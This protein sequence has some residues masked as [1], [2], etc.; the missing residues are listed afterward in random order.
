MDE[1]LKLQRRMAEL[2]QA[3]RGLLDAAKAED[4]PL[5]D[6]ER[7]KFDAN[8]AEVETCK[9]RIGD[10]QEQ[11]RAEAELA[12]STRQAQDEAPPAAA[13]QAQPVAPAERRAQQ[14]QAQPRVEVRN[15]EDHNL[16]MRFGLW[17]LEVR[18]A[19]LG[20]GIGKR[21]EASMQEHRAATGM[22]TAVGSDG[23]FLLM[24]DVSRE[25][26][27][28]MYEL[29]AIISRVRKLPALPEG[30]DGVS[31]PAVNETS[32]VT[33]S[34][35][36]GVQGYWLA[37]GSAPT[38]SKPKLKEIDLRLNGVGALGYAT[39]RLLKFAAILGSIMLDAM[40]EEL[41][42]LTE[43]AII[44]GTGAGQ[45]K[46]ILNADALVTVSAEGGQAAATILAQNIVKIWSRV[47]ARCRPNTV[48]LIN[49]DI[50]PQLHLMTLA[51]GTG[52]V[53][54]YLPANGLAGE[55]YGT[56]FGRPVIPVEYCSTLGTI[57]DIMAVD[58]SQ[59][60]LIDGGA[61]ETASSIHV[62]FTQFE[63][64][65]RAIYYVDGRPAW[66]SPLTP[67]Q[68]SNTLSAFVALATRS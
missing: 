38:A 67:A 7:T 26:F 61:T 10:L 1:I 39:D 58:L 9:R 56:L 27:R 19:A 59:Y 68:G 29:G 24:T 25:I 42:F 37:E 50:E 8:K 41:L 6:E 57:G 46:G 23:G 5:N 11:E 17:L 51:V 35:M 28:R 2:V 66:H 21:L 4:R 49:Q 36:G 33:G 43:N 63:Q 55:P 65:F 62:L 16:A 31:I 32:R 34:R 45:P 18:A 48:F 15:H 14:R 47:W 20:Q 13:A 12:Q 53:P 52:G 22:G 40:A 54:V 3:N 60:L 44:R 64:A 30:A